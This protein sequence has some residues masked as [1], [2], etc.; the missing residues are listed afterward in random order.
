MIKIKTKR[1]Y[2][3]YNTETGN[4]LTKSMYHDTPIGRG[5]LERDLHKF[6]MLKKTVAVGEAFYQGKDI[7]R[8]VPKDVHFIGFGQ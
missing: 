3:I 7:T 1:K 5:W 6:S 4:V 8:T 2:F